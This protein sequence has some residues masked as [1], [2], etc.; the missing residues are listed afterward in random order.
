[1]RRPVRSEITSRA[2]SLWLSYLV[3]E[4]PPGSGATALA[5]RLARAIGGRLVLDRARENPFLKDFLTDPR[6]YAFKTQL[7]FTLSRIMQQQE[8]IVQRDLFQPT[9]VTD[10]LFARDRLYSSLT[11]DDRE[12]ALYEKLAGVIERDIHRPDLVVYLQY[13]SETLLSRLKDRS[14]EPW[15]RLGREY[16]VAVVEAYNYYF[17]HY[18]ETP[19]LII[20]GR[21]DDP[22]RSDEALKRLVAELERTH[23]GVRYYN[24]GG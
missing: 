1:M 12:L 19:L 4:G 20:N 18:E 11:L 7:F 3:V 21:Q 6:R 2:E 24:P 14:E 15:L 9:V 5:T 17:L 13:D 10:Y 23:A 16:L 22:G 8:A